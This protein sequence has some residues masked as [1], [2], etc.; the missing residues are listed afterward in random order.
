V[1]PD[2]FQRDYVEQLRAE[3]AANRVKA[4]RADDLAARL[5]LAIAE[6][7]GKLIDASDLAV[8]AEVL[9][10]FMDDDGMPDEAKVQEAVARL[11]AARPHLARPVFAGDV[12][13]GVTGIT[14][15]G[16]GLGAMLR[17]AAL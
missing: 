17:Q 11:I 3:A 15:A 16:P 4:K 12:G 1:E 9:P 8:S 10:E 14:E 2:V 13:Q 6:G 5:V 7:T